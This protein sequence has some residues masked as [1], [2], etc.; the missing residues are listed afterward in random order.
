MGKERS[1]LMVMSIRLESMLDRELEGR[2]GGV[3][4]GQDGLDRD[5]E[6]EGSF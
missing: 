5:V 4:L 2:E 3:E 6:E 1:I